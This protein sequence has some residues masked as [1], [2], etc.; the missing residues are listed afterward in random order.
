MTNR[1][2]AKRYITYCTN[3]SNPVSSWI[4]KNVR[5]YLADMERVDD[6]D[7]PFYFDEDA[8][9]HVIG[10]FEN[11]QFSLGKWSQKNFDL[12][13]WQLFILW[14]AYG[15]K[16]KA[17]KMRRYN[18]IYIKVARK[19]GKTEFLS[20]IGIYGQFFDP[21]EKDAQIYWFAT[22]K[23]QAAIGFSRQKTMTSLLTKKSG[24]FATMVRIYQYSISSRND[25]SYTRYLGQDSKT[26]DGY[27]PF[28]GLCD[29]YHAHQTDGMINV[30][31]SGMGSRDS[32]MTWIIT[33]AGTNPD[34]PCAQ[35]ERHL[36]QGLDG[37]IPLNAELPFIFDLDEGDDWKDESVW[38]KA[39]PGL[40]V[41]VSMAFLRAAYLKANTQGV[42]KRMNFQTKNLN[43]W[44]KANSVWI[45][46]DDWKQNAGTE[47][48]EQMRES[49]KGRQ[50]YGGLDLAL[51]SDLSVLTLCFPP[52]SENE[53]VKFLS[54]AWC[55]DATADR[56]FQLDAVPYFEWAEKGYLELTPG[57]VTDFN[58][59]KRKI[60]ELWDTYQIHSIGYDP[61]AATHIVTDL[62]AAGVVME[63]YR[64]TQ[65]NMSPSIHKFER[66]AISQ[67]MAHG[68]DPVLSWCV[69]N[70]Q[71]KMY[72]NGNVMMDKDKS[73]EK[74]DAAVSAVM[75]FGQW[76]EH[77]SE[78]GDQVYAV[79]L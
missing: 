30:V 79:V 42:A 37:I 77:Y 17:D 74:I 49:L 35:F 56:R 65:P 15:W 21:Y 18:Q 68:N 28:Y 26:E 57:N 3:E 33:T 8:A 78:S 59:I 31:E 76:Q 38:A 63:T 58:Y 23:E 9:D 19:N 36:K 52:E 75:S 5:M 16:N 45:S 39:N 7:F 72:A 60:T 69:S 20:G 13:D 32:P 70:V 6:P 44:L 1:Q 55:P 51:V 27:S 73:S 71:I 34:G 24:W 4:R 41:S 29:E 53:P 40:G 50:C 2:R 46:G 43:M 22:K 25:S 67:G 54:W 12:D 62:D 10:V 64:Q 61:H 48:V 11:L 14:C 66:L 47:T